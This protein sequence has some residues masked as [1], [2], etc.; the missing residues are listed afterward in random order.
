VVDTI[1]Y[2]P[3]RLP[4]NE[5]STAIK[6]NLSPLRSRR[7]VVLVVGDTPVVEQV[8]RVLSSRGE[9]VRLMVAGSSEEAMDRIAE[10]FPDLTIIDTSAGSIEAGVIATRLRERRP[11]ERVPM[12]ALLEPELLTVNVSFLPNTG[13]GPIPLTRLGLHLRRVLTAVVHPGTSSLLSEQDTRSD[14]IA[15]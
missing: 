2:L 5:L 14:V 3:L 13:T 7:E 12:I 6:A 4:D 9:A 1:R 10:S 15:A 11:N 8:R